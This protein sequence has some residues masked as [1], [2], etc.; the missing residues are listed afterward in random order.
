MYMTRCLVPF[1]ISVKY[2][3]N[4]PKGIW[5]TQGTWNLFQTKQSEIIPKVSK[6]ELSFLYVTRRLVLFYNS[7]KYHQNIP[8]GIQVTEPTRKF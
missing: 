4:I 2:H 7:S 8:K 3:Q 6:P 5:A 1:Y